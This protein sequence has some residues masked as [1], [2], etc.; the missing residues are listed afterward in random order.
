MSSLSIR[1][2]T[3]LSILAFEVAGCYT[4]TV[5]SGL[6]PAP[7]TI[8][9]DNKWHSGVV[10]GIAELSGPYDLHAICPRGWAD[11]RTETSFVNGFIDL[12]TSGI[13]NPQSVTIRCTSLPAT[14]TQSQS[15]M[16]P[17]GAPRRE[18]I[19]STAHP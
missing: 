8:A 13:Y 19:E 17:A 15:R 11:I 3:A 1:L 16:T 12:V 5:Q 2:G 4:T 7:P 9:D 10:L 18:S 14:V 6:P